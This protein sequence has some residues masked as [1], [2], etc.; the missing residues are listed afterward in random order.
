MAMES[1]HTRWT[2]PTLLLLVVSGC[3]LDAASRGPF[4]PEDPETI[5]PKTPL[6]AQAPARHI[7]EFTDDESVGH[8]KPKMAGM[9]DEAAIARSPNQAAVLSTSEIVALRK[10]AEADP[11]VTSLLGDR[12]GFIDADLLSP[13]DK[14]AFGCCRSHARLVRLT[15]FS[16]SHN[17]AIDVRTKDRAVLEVSRNEGYLPAEGPQDVQR[18]IELARA[19]PRLA[20]KVQALQG[21]GLLMQPDR[22]FFTHDPGYEH[23]V[24]WITFSQGQDGDPKY[25]AQVDLTEDRVLDAG[26]EP[27]R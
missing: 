5:I 1:R 23:R 13:Q 2:Y 21:H 4:G 25:W 15:Y 11:R 16:Y 17:V 26:E 20:G 7:L 14:I 10:A 12:W 8:I 22:G 3:S 19:D 27:P 6:P 24:I 9:V 18:G